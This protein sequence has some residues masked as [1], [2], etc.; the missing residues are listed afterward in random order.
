[1][2]HL[3]LP[4]FLFG[5]AISVLTASAA[6]TV[7]VHVFV[8]EGCV[9]CADEKAFLVD[10]EE[11]ADIDVILHDIVLE[12]ERALFER[13]LTAVTLPRATP[14][15]V[16]GPIV[17]QGF[18]TAETTGR[19]L[20]SLI[21]SSRDKTLP[22]I[23]EA[24]QGGTLRTQRGGSA[25]GED[26]TVPCADDGSA[27]LVRIPLTSFTIDAQRFSLPALA[28]LLGF[29]DGFNPC[30]MW[31][32]VTFL[33]VLLQIGDRR[34]VWQVAGLFIL[35][36]TVMYYLILNVWYTTWD[37]IGLD[38]IVTPIVGILAMGGGLFFLYEGTMSDG[39][40]KVT[41]LQQRR[42]T[43][44][45][46]TDIATRPF[47]M[48]TAVA[49]IGLALSVN[50][51]EFACSIGIPQAFTKI[52]DLN[53]VSFV[54]RHGLMLLYILGYM[55]DDFIVFGIA[56]WGIDRLDLTHRYARASNVIGGVLMLALG[57]L[58]IFRP[59]L[60]HVW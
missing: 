49:V 1:M 26:P 43:H 23:E 32:L 10:L 59:D 4:I 17:V 24:L 51:I 20:E 34:K 8:R 2:Q 35:A 22:T 28:S 56:L 5:F 54:A 42:R 7:P 9:H 14:V 16:V 21:E 53:G 33:I 37:F 13:V 55:I 30:A 45:R 58:L 46:I 29:I 52:L 57:M 31:V 36:E 19:S 50:I 12:N 18:D 38:R 48:L 44:L 27:F 41:N 40:C 6:E 11:R 47:T 15:T 3:R 39:T 60:L 25:C